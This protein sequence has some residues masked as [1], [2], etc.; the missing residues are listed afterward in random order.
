MTA[1]WWAW[2]AFF[3]LWEGLGLVADIH[4]RG[5]GQTLSGQVWYWLKVGGRRPTIFT[6]VLRIAVLAGWVWLGPHLLFGWW[7]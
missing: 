2:M 7:S 5:P 4:G 6:W 3:V 1:G